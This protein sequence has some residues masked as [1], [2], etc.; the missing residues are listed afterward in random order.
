MSTANSDVNEVTPAVQ[1]EMYKDLQRLT[2]LIQEHDHLYYTPGLSPKISDEEYDALTEREAALCRQNPRFLKRLEQESSLGSKVSRYGGRVG[3]IISSDSQG[4]TGGKLFHLEKSPMQS[5]DNAMMS[6]Q[7]VKW[8]N[9]VRR[10][11][12]KARDEEDDDDKV[13]E[14]IAEPK[15]DGLS[16]S[17]RYVLHDEAEKHY[18]LEWGAT[19][20]DGK[21]G[22]N[23]TDAINA[24]DI[25]PKTFVF[26]TQREL[27]AVI[28]VRGEVVLPTSIFETLSKTSCAI[29]SSCD[30]KGDDDGQETNNEGNQKQPAD[31][32]RPLLSNTFSNARNAAS[33]ILMRRK[34][35]SEMKDEEVENTRKFRSF[36]RFYAYSIAFSTEA[37]NAINSI[38][39]SDGIEMRQVLETCGF[40]VPNP[41]Q[42]IPITL[43]K[44]EEVVESD[45]QTLFDYHSSVMSNRHEASEIKASDSQSFTFDFDVDGAVY[46]VSNVFDR[47]VLGSSSRVPRWA[48]AHKFPAQCAIT[49]LQGIEI[50]IGRTGAITPVAVLDAVDLGGVSV[51]R[52]SLHNFDFA[53]SILKATNKDD[54][55]G[56][57]KGVSVMISRA[58][59]VIPQVLQRLDDVIEKDADD[60]ISL[61]PPSRCP[62]CGSKTVFDLVGSRRKDKNAT[63]V[64]NANTIFDDTVGID[65]KN[66]SQTSRNSIGQ[67]LRC[68]GPQLLC[69]PRAV[70][71]LA[72]TFSR[73]GLDISGLS[74]ARLQQLFNA[75]L[76][77]VPA[78]LFQI[79]DEDAD[80]FQNIIDLPGWGD[81]SALNLKSALQRVASEGVTLSKF[82]YSLGIRH[83][84]VQSSSL[85]ASAY[86]S[87][88]AFF[89]AIDTASQKEF[90]QDDAK[91][92]HFSVLIG[93]GN[94]KEGVKG[95]GPVAIDSLMKF[96]ANKELVLAAKALAK[97]I[98]VLDT[99]TRTR[100][101]QS[102]DKDLSSLP[103]NQLSVVFTGSLPGEMTRSNAQHFAVELLGAKSTPSNV[104]KTTGIVVVGEKGGKK[105][106]KANEYGIT[107]MSASE[108]ADLVKKH[109]N[110]VN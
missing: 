45:C 32:F 89:D 55:V 60:F 49:T 56:V 63:N 77:R 79:L 36:L 101:D 35:V 9:R 66:K 70:G 74:E 107:I 47:A 62:S 28:E 73:E 75:T 50:Q 43:R 81:K 87:L 1:E 41:Y 91:E 84:G 86:T 44:E 24:M 76:I 18:K 72:H 104:S 94:S 83:L 64:T 40:A 12:F 17:L 99:I 65:I 33:G 78:D 10:I 90:D 11:L 68:S 67:V 39:Y 22:E 85:I 42:V 103:F 38:Y 82:I 93:D 3:P 19:R 13:I 5:L 37:S 7:V 57:T 102:S 30:E 58:G 52:A 106:D 27:P 96:A 54:D 2:T 4:G 95:I 46:K 59:D 97:I 48:I 15:M 98:P 14:I 25:I 53:Q 26:D 51:S 80:L 34:S 110:L 23:V 92:A 21:R 108:F 88:D 20:G 100:E 109:S 16:L 71:A 61:Q 29:N 105:R 6:T 69:K 31:Q 8:M